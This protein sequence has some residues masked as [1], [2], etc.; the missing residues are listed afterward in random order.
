MEKRGENKAG[1][2]RWPTIIYKSTPPQRDPLLRRLFCV[3]SRAFYIFPEYVF[4]GKSK[5]ICE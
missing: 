3:Y 4:N 5:G 2:Q 1:E